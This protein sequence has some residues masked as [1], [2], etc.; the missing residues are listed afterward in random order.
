MKYSKLSA[1]IPNEVKKM[2]ISQ[3]AIEAKVSIGTVDR[4]LHNR[5]RVAQETKEKIL[6]IAKENGYEPNTFARNLKLSKKF[7][8]AI[9]LPRLES[10]YSYWSLPYEGIL[11]AKNE[12][13]QLSV[14]IKLI[15]F[16]RND[17]TSL[18]LALNELE[19]DEIDGAIIAPVFPEETKAF[20]DKKQ[21]LPYV[22]IDSPLPD[23]KPLTS[24]AQD[25]Y[26]SGYVAGKMMALLA[27][28]CGTF[29]VVES[30]ND[31]FNSR[32]RA[33]GFASFFNSCKECKVKEAL[34]RFNGDG[35]EKLQ[36]IFTEETDIKGIFIVND[37]THRLAEVLDSLSLK[38]RPLVIGFD[39]IEQNKEAMKQGKIDCLISQRPF[40]Q[41]YTALYHLYRKCVL[42]QE[43]EEEII[44]PIDIV[45]PENLSSFDQ[46]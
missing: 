18:I 24:L 12:L 26:Q 13:S 4:V 25:P 8:F 46:Q 44:I 2:T 19:N 10:E 29:I 33:R 30:H 31:A 34:I 17:K 36:R 20:L 3:I 1:T 38:K 21:D 37:A 5:G 45:L 16:D 27:K 22:F 9:I 40:Y 42:S 28:E 11:K 32:E 39:L 41:G 23:L 6:A 7:T 43:I 35:K 14:F 15:E